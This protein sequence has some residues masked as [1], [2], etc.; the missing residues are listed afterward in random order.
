MKISKYVRAHEDVIIEWVY[1]S[2]LYLDN[3]YGILVDNTNNTKSFTFIAPNDTDAIIKD[4]QYNNIGNQLY[5]VDPV[6]NRWR[7]AD[8]NKV[9]SIQLQKHL[10][11]SLS[12][13]DTVKVHFPLN[14][15][16]NEHR[17]FYLGIYAYNYDTSEVYYLSNYYYD[18]EQSRDD[19]KLSSNPDI[20]YEIL[21]GKYIELNVPSIYEE[22]KNRQEFPNTPISGTINYNIGGNSVSSGF[23]PNSPI[24]VDFRFIEDKITLLNEPIYISTEQRA[25]SFPQTSEHQTLGVRVEP[26][27]DGDYFSIYGTYGD[28]AGEFALFMDELDKQGQKNYL[29][30]VI[31]VFEEGMPTDRV[32]YYVH[33]NFDKK[34]KYR[35]ILQYTNTVAN[36]EVTMKVVNTVDN[37]VLTRKADYGMLSSEVLKHGSSRLA[38]SMS[39]AYKPK[40]YNAKADQVI[41]SPTVATGSRRTQ[42]QKLTE[43][44]LKEVVRTETVTEIKTINKPYP[45]LITQHNVVVKDLNA[46]NN[47][48][49]HYGQGQLN[50][51]LNPFDNI[52]KIKISKEV[53]E[54]ATVPLDLNLSYDAR[55]NMTFSA[56][57]TTVNIPV[58][59]ESDEL[60]IQ[61]GIVIF[62]IKS[63]EIP[64][65]ERI[66][67]S[68]SV[69]YI[70]VTSN[71]NTTVVYRGTFTMAHL[72]AKVTPTI[73]E[74]LP[75][76][77]EVIKPVVIEEPIVPQQPTPIY[78]DRRPRHQDIDVAFEAET[79]N[80]RYYKFII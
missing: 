26:A 49:T 14:Y 33:E 45:L 58:Y 61:N 48:D 44:K 13:F 60:S 17:G 66:Y 29:L 3:D 9:P 63:S 57:G 74:P 70:T 76:I 38:I 73:T 62:L 69:F 15:N 75:P 20:H 27:L 35:P 55:V 42:T 8:P 52:F 47:G 11:P 39:N 5:S 56:D 24:F 23:S 34:I 72:A 53:S 40:I 46:T 68:S 19:I 32:Q 1:D 18:V 37:S 43:I 67:K 80:D 36:I 78:T 59:A 25:V 16:F 54:A 28:S 64:N 30:Y 10:N 65:I 12:R 51:N 71:G 50:I 4:K 6:L 22:A 2:E 41:V 31:D 21:W 7:N 79:L 77:K